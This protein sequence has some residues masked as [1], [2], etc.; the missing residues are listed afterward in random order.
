VATDRAQPLS[1]LRRGD[2]FGVR[3]RATRA[4]L[5]STQC[6]WHRST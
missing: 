1:A 6:G 4:R 5:R 2:C 3:R